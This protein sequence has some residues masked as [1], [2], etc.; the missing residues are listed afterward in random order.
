VFLTTTTVV[1]TVAVTVVTI[2]H[3][4]LAAVLFG[5]LGGIL[6][7]GAIADL[8]SG[9]IPNS[10]MTVG[11][12][13]A[14]ALD[15]YVGGWVYGAIRV[16]IVTAIWL[17]FVSVPRVR[18]S[19]GG[20]DLKMIGVTWLTF[21]VFGAFGGLVAVLAWELALLT[22]FAILKLR[23]IQHF[24]AGPALAGAAMFAWIVVLY[25]LR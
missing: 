8:Q 6:T 25:S 19:T 3:T 11:A 16:G 24:R 14:I 18:R 2:T 13:A 4:L 1:V 17:I 15:L 22:V 5:F 21:S 12:L 9:K 7:L 10:V 23:K 20:G